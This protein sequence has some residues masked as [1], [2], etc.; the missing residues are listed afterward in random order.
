LIKRL[1][2]C[3]HRH[4]VDEHPA[5]F[6]EGNVVV[7]DLKN[8]EEHPWF[9]NPGTRIGYLDIETD[10]LKADF[11]TMLTWCI[12]EKGGKVYYDTVTKRELFE[13][14]SDRRIVQSIVDE[15][16]KYNIIVGYY[17]TGFDLPFVRAKALHYGIDFPG[18]EYNGKTF[19]PELYHFD[20]YYTVKSKLC[21]SRKSLDA[22][23]DYLNISGKTPISK[24]AWR[25]AKYGDPEALNTVLE[26]NVGDVE[27]LE[28]LHDKMTTFSK[29]TKRGV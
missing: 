10:N 8:Q 18:F 20:L 13:G 23:C 11:G 25:R 4:T 9:Q 26:H 28:K 19:V 24:D 21:I 7:K 14:D 15:M 3:T 6:F 16:R 5:C 22:A 17:S 29:W 12:K 2:R 1:L 27:I